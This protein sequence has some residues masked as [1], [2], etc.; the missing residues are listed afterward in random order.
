MKRFKK[1]YVEKQIFTEQIEQL[2]EHDI[3][4]EVRHLG[5][6]Y[7]FECIKYLLDRENISFGQLRCAQFFN[8]HD[9]YYDINRAA[10]YLVRAGLIGS[11]QVDKN[12][13]VLLDAQTNK[14]LNDWLEKNGNLAL[15]YLQLIK[16]LEERH[17]FM[18]SATL[19]KLEQLASKTSYKPYEEL[20]KSVIA[21]EIKERHQLNKTVNL[22]NVLTTTTTTL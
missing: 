1:K 18:D 12:N 19:T 3:E 6:S 21:Q 14:I 11:K 4:N 15:L 13:T 10:Y 2:K 17:F 7:N 5:L 9:Y 16:Q 8:G 22:L 20:I